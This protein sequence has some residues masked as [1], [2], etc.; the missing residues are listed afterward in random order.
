LP[1]NQCRDAVRVVAGYYLQDKAR[2]LRWLYDN[3]E[4]DGVGLVAELMDKAGVS[5]DAWPLWLKD[6]LKSLTPEARSRATIMT[7]QL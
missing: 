6:I 2:R 4:D 3:G 5:S 7:T 1:E